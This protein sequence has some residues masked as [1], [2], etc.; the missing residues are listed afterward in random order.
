[1]LDNKL[2]DILNHRFF[3]HDLPKSF[4]STTKDTEYPRIKR[5]VKMC[6]AASR[7]IESKVNV[8]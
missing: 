3:T 1:M 7:E 5:C 8:G 6:G 2:H 4:N